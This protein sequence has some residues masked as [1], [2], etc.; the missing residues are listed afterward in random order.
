MFGT[1]EGTREGWGRKSDRFCWVPETKKT[2]LL[3]EPHSSLVFVTMG[4]QN[5]RGGGNF[6]AIGL[7]WD[8][9]RDEGRVGEEVRSF[10]LG[11]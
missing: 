6:K 1:W 5:A 2:R 7:V 8:L 3:W 9:G 11:S 4:A 10:F